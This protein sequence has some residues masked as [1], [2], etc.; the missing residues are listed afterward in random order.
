MP[1]SDNDGCYVA[2]DAHST[3]FEQG[4]KQ[5]LS[6]AVAFRVGADGRKQ[7]RIGLQLIRE[8]SASDTYVREMLDRVRIVAG[9]LIEFR[10]QIRG[11]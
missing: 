4:S 5:K 3:D 11:D 9:E 8:R 1:G 2:V 10:F 6:V 7:S